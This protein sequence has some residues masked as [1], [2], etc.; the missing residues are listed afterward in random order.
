VL[1]RSW[2]LH[3]GIFL[4]PLAMRAFLPADHNAAWLT[5]FTLETIIYAVG[6]A[7]IVMLMVKDHLPYRRV[8]RS[9]DRA[10]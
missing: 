4:V 9:P 2:C 7:F 6:T 8:H 5:V 1:R 3:A 10:P